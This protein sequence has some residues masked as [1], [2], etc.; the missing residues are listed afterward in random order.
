MDINWFDSLKQMKVNS[1]MTTFE[2]SEKS[3]VPEPTLEKLFSGYTKNPKLSTVI[4]V[5]HCF[6]KTLD[7]L[8]SFQT[9]QLPPSEDRDDIKEQLIENYGSMNDA[10]QLELLKHS[11]LLLNDNQYKKCDEFAMG[12]GTA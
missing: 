6:G 5:T 4:A 7:D 1:G 10:G 11:R 8:I 9:K 12:K 2:I 3:N